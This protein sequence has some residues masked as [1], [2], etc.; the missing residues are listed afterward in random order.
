MTR[1]P[2]VV[3]L[4]AA[5]CSSIVAACADP[6]EADADRNAILSL[7]EDQR[8]AHFQGSAPMF[9]AASVEEQLRGG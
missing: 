4:A 8:E 1:I 2:L 6:A 7:Y 3:P 5:A 9:L